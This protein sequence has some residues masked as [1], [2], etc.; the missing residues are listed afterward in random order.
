M[1]RKLYD[2]SLL[3]TNS[4]NAR[5]KLA[6]FKLRNLLLPDAVSEVSNSDENSRL[7]VSGAAIEQQPLFVVTLGSQEGA[8]EN[9]RMTYAGDHGPL[10]KQLLQTHAIRRTSMCCLASKAKK[11]LI[12]THEKGKP[13][14]YLNVK[15][16]SSGSVL[17]RYLNNWVI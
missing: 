16:K 7:V 13:K 5:Q 15:I 3:N 14:K 8:F 2:S 9:V 11:H 4:L 6:K 17:E 10:I 12:V 1:A